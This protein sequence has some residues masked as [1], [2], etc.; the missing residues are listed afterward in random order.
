MSVSMYGSVEC[1]EGHLDD[2]RY[3]NDDMKISFC[4]EDFTCRDMP[5]IWNFGEYF[6]NKVKRYFLCFL[7]GIVLKPRW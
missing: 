5:V 1:L 6:R 2:K 3:T 7:G 4:S